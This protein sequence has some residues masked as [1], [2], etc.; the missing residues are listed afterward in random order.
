MKFFKFYKVDASTGTSVEVE[1]PVEGPTNP[2]LAGLANIFEFGGWTYATADDAAAA[3]DDNYIFE[4]TEAA[5]IAV[6]KDEFNTLKCI[7][8]H[9]YEKNDQQTVQ[10][11]KLILQMLEK[12][13]HPMLKYINEFKKK[14]KK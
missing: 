6:I 11:N 12:I 3:D 14:N 10:F 7:H 9:L 8:T 13:N 4:I 2:S 5:Y 1:A